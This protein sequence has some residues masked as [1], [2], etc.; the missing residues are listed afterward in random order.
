MEQTR[1]QVLATIVTMALVGIGTWVFC[2]AVKQEI[3]AKKSSAPVAVMTEVSQSGSAR[4]TINAKIMDENLGWIELSCP[5]PPSDVKLWAWTYVG[6]G[7]AVT[8]LLPGAGRL[9]ETRT[10][11]EFESADARDVTEVIVRER[12]VSPPAGKD[13]RPQVHVMADCRAYLDGKLIYEPNDQCRNRYV[14]AA[15][16]LKKDRQWETLTTATPAENGDNV[17]VSHVNGDGYAVRIA[18]PAA[19]RLDETQ[20]F[21]KE[22]G[23]SLCGESEST[24]I[25]T[26]YV[27]AGEQVWVLAGCKAFLNNDLIYD[28]PGF[29]ESVYRI[30]P[31]E[32]RLDAPMTSAIRS[33]V[34]NRFNEMEEVRQ[35]AE[36]NRCWMIVAGAVSGPLLHFSNPEWELNAVV[37]GPEERNQWVF[38]IPISPDKVLPAGVKGAVCLRYRYQGSAGMNNTPNAQYRPGAVSFFGW[39]QGADPDDMDQLEIALVEE[40]GKLTTIHGGESK[41]DRF[42]K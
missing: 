24:V 11:T 29:F 23:I 21:R 9:T 7:M 31:A 15:E 12:L 42:L 2:V 28:P 3:E 17:L 16:I 26:R 4:D 41:L 19:G 20:Q 39:P 10:Q 33:V 38:T 34:K 36:K 37:F 40:D 13:C 22:M 18:M 14:R 25:R 5:M 27:S 35:Y 1:W 32:I 8:L 6:H 30:D